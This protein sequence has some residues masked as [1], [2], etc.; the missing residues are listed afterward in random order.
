M[1][2]RYNR[3]NP[4]VYLLESKE[5][6]LTNKNHLCIKYMISY[7]IQMG[8]YFILSI[9]YAIITNSFNYK[10][11]IIV[12]LLGVFVVLEVVNGVKSIKTQEI[13]EM[14]FGDQYKDISVN[15]EQLLAR[16]NN[17]NIAI[18]KIDFLIESIIL[19]MLILLFLIGIN[20]ISIMAL[21]FI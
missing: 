5:I 20:I 11:Y 4:F 8:I 9:S 13:N 6:E 18:G 15:N 14:I 7:F 21:I 19:F 12:I 17:Y 1:M 10:E 2:N 16:I 3:Q